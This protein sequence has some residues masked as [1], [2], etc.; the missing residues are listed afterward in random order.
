MRTQRYY[1]MLCYTHSVKCCKNERT[2]RTHE[3]DYSR[4]FRFGFSWPLYS[5]FIFLFLTKTNFCLNECGFSNEKKNTMSAN[6]F[7]LIFLTRRLITVSAVNVRFFIRSDGKSRSHF[8]RS[9]VQ[10]VKYNVHVCNQ[11]AII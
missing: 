10:C 6:I 5:F 9:T 1:Y 8:T 3:T 4:S 2:A 11:Y 7:L